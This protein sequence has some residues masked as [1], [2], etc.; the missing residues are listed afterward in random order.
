MLSHPPRGSPFLTAV[1]AGW[2]VVVFLFNVIVLG[3]RLGQNMSLIFKH[4]HVELSG[5]IK[6]LVENTFLLTVD[7]VVVTPI[8]K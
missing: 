1:E 8:A 3:K 5:R 7:S 2:L 6:S 4:S